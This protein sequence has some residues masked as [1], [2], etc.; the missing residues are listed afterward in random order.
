MVVRTG[1][2]GDITGLRPSQLAQLH[3][4]RRGWTGNVCCGRLGR[5]DRLAGVVCDGSGTDVLDLCSGRTFPKCEAANERS[6]EREL[7]MGQSARR[8]API[9]RYYPPRS[10]VAVSGLAI[11]L[12][13]RKPFH[14]Q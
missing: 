8:R 2:L 5:G 6:P 11:G 4:Y 13:A 10:A 7:R 9:G 3:V 14:A 12:D 1:R